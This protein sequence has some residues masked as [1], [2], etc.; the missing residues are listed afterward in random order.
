MSRTGLY[1]QW[2]VSRCLENV[3]MGKDS[4]AAIS[5]K[6]K[7]M[8]FALLKCAAASVVTLADAVSLQQIFTLV[9]SVHRIWHLSGNHLPKL[10]NEISIN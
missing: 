7:S 6:T 8:A 9:L 4:E 5:A 3:E 10:M 1:R 2:V